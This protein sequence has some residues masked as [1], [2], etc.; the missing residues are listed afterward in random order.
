MQYAVCVSSRGH[1]VPLH[2]GSTRTSFL[3][4]LSP[5]PQLWEQR[6][7][8][9]QSLTTQSTDAKK[10]RLEVLKLTWTTYIYVAILGLWRLV[11]AKCPTIH[12][13]LENYLQPCRGASFTCCC[14]VAPVAPLPRTIN[15]GV[16][17][18][19]CNM[20]I[21]KPGQGLG[22]HARLSKRWWHPI[23]RY[24]CGPDALMFLVSVPLPHVAEHSPHSPKSV[25]WQS[26]AQIELSK[27]GHRRR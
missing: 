9:R 14:A 17:W 3:R 8:S 24:P 10:D 22:L 1:A 7:Q 23:P 6:P 2:C 26:T 15:C 12:C 5:P 19:M 20:T 11:R 25:T 18:N 27:L 21:M 16:D 13:L 4:P